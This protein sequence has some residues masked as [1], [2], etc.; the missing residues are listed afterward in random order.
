M[1][2]EHEYHPSAFKHERAQGDEEE[3]KSMVFVSGSPNLNAC[4]RAFA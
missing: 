2:E 1:K 3:R 4:T